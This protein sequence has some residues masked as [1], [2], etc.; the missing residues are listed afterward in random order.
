MEDVKKFPLNKADEKGRK[1]GKRGKIRNQCAKGRIDITS[2]VLADRSP[3]KVKAYDFYIP[4]LN[5]LFLS[6]GEGPLM[7]V[8]ALIGFDVKDTRPCGGFQCPERF[9]HDSRYFYC[10]PCYLQM[11]E[12]GFD[13][14]KRCRH[15]ISDCDHYPEC[16]LITCM[17]DDIDR[18]E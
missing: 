9:Y 10:R 8:F 4:S 17:C 1:R 3:P 6:I 5:P 11:K 2:L 14:C 7:I 16:G 13:W 12:D 15:P 18:C